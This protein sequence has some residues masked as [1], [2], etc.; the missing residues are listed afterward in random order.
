[1]DDSFVLSAAIA[2]HGLIEIGCKYK[3]IFP[4]SDKMS[5]IFVAI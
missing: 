4:Y 1:M 5:V 2:G 3:S